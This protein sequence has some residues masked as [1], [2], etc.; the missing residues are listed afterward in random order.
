MDTAATNTYRNTP[1][2]TITHV[3]TYHS[4]LNKEANAKTSILTEQYN[5]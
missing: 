1:I 3:M 4:L 5:T 2:K